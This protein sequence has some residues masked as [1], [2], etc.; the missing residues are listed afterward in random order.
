MSIGLGLERLGLWTLARQRIGLVLVVMLCVLSALLIPRLSFD[1]GLL[2]QRIAD[3]RVWSDYTT[4][5]DAFGVTAPSLNIV[6]HPPEREDDIEPWLKAQSGLV[7]DLRLLDG[8]ADVQ[9]IFS[10]R[11][12]METGAG[13][14][15]LIPI[16]DLPQGLDALENLVQS[17]SDAALFMS[18]PVPYARMSIFISPSQSG[19]GEV[20]EAVLK[21]IAEFE[22]TSQFTL[23]LSGPSIVQAEISKALMRDLRLMVL[24]S[25]AIGWM[26][27]LF[28]FTNI[29]AAAICNIAGPVAMLWTAGFVA[30]TGTSLNA[31]TIILPLLSSVIAFADTVHLVVPF[32]RRLAQGEDR[33]DSIRYVMKHVGPASALTSVTTALAFG[34]LAIAGG[35]MVPGRLVGGYGGFAGLGLCHD[36]GAFALS[37]DGQDVAWDH[38]GEFGGRS[39]MVPKAG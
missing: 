16:T 6:F 34:S 20:I 19:A 2:K 18:S 21:V 10:L 26:V 11:R 14:Q 39:G 13:T 36:C 32:Q 8:V 33:L 30:L 24:A 7:F 37:G 17:N 9:S 23:S 3:D 38:P 15:P 28:F 1:D 4:I 27:G 29:R 31:I 12:P 35:A 25:T 22:Q 5:Q